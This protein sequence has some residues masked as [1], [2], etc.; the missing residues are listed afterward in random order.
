[1]K[2]ILIFGGTRF[3]GKKVVTHFLNLGYD[4][5][6]AT[7][8]TTPDS[9]GQEVSRLIIDRGDSSH[10]GWKEIQNQHW[11]IVF[12]NICF[13]Q[14]DAKIACHYLTDVQH[15]L[16][17]SS[18]ATY[19]GEASLDGYKE[20]NFIPENYHTEA[21][22]DSDYEYGE[23]K[24]EA[25]SYLAHN[26]P[27]KVT[28]L[29]FPIVLDDDDYTERL[30]FY[31]KAALAKETIVFRRKTG[32]F[33]FVRASEIPSMLE[34]I[35]LNNL[36]G[37]INLASDQIYSTKDFIIA[38]KMALNL[39]EL[40]VIYDSTQTPS[41]FSKY[42]EP[43]DTSLLKKQGYSVTSLDSWLPS[44]MTRLGEDEIKKTSKR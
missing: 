21:T 11:H 9:F 18:L 33:S 6:I 24:R 44:L 17:T 7:R 16:V 20:S 13:T 39:D 12:D 1:M 36:T 15:Y 26:Y 38:L 32:R 40:T 23:G 29:R 8:G 3:F 31:V 43:L 41:P 42:D 4:V 34:F 30:H 27:G 28:Y 25:E 10:I 37:P 22:S 19:Q 2:K 35:I 14:N 5:T